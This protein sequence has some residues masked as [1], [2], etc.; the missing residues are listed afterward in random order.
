MA[1]CPVNTVVL[2]HLREVSVAVL[3]EV[4]FRSVAPAQELGVEVVVLLAG[5]VFPDFGLVMC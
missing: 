3:M 5:A 4:A 2:L 1:F